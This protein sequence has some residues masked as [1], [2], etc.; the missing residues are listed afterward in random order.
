[1]DQIRFIYFVLCESVFARI[2]FFSKLPNY[3][4]WN[5]LL[6][7][8]IFLLFSLLSKAKFSKN[9]V[10]LLEKSFPKNVSQNI[11]K[12]VSQ[13]PKMKNGIWRRHFLS[14][15]L[16]TFNFFRIHFRDNCL[17]LKSLR[18]QSIREVDWFPTNF[19]KNFL[20]FFR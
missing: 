12:R 2:C 7:L 11:F 20:I 15:D 3:S 5:P 18:F 14:F 10:N 4:F 13:N 19:R 1:M 9:Q 8:G 17:C 6:F 16:K